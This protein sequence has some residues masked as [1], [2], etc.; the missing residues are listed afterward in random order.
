MNGVTLWRVN[1]SMECILIH[2]TRSFSHPCGL[3]GAFIV[4]TGVGFGSS[5][6]SYL[7]T[8]SG[9]AT[10][11]LNGTLVECFGP[12]FSRSLGNMIG[13]STLQLVGELCLF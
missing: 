12:V 2:S 13:N 11:A 8:L 7:S 4:V 6:T 10:S 1:G 9:T 3:G 5:A